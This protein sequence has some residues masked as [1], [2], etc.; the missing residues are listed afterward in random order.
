MSTQLR[1]RVLR[2]DRLHHATQRVQ[3]VETLEILR[4]DLDLDQALHKLALD[5][6]RG[7]TLTPDGGLAEGTN[8][9]LNLFDCGE[10]ELGEAA[11]DRVVEGKGLGREDTWREGGR[12]LI[13]VG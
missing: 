10:G 4:L 7:G 12:T 5:D 6:G 3:V 9:I 2:T 13:L 1:G 8:R 11:D